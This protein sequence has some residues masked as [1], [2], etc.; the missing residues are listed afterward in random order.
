MRRSV[1]G[2]LTPDA[3]AAL[4]GTP[5]RQPTPD[6][7]TARAA[8]FELRS[9]GLTPRDVASALKLSE[10]AVRALLGNRR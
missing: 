5:H 3:L 9:R 2:L 10:G 1:G 6:R 8:A 7:D 4:Y